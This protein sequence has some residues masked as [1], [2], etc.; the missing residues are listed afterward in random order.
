MAATGGEYVVCT[1]VDDKLSV[2]CTKDAAAAVFVC[3]SVAAMGD[4]LVTCTDRQVDARG[5]CTFTVEFNV[6]AVHLVE[7]D[8]LGTLVLLTGGDGTLHVYTATDGKL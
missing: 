2:Y 7:H 1:D 8:T 4:S 6:V 5:K 3:D